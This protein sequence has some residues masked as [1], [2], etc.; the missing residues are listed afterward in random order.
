MLK[1][2]CWLS[3]VLVCVLFLIG[4]CSNSE[5]DNS[6][7]AMSGDT[8]GQSSSQAQEIRVRINDDPD[9]LDPHHATASISFQMILNMFE[10]LFIPEQDGSL[11]E[12]VAESYEVSERHLVLNY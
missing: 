5:G 1:R 8:N 11:T 3:F 4:A 6:S 2:K 7:T 10:G 9:F 12:G